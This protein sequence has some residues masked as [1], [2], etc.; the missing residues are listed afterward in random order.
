MVWLSLLDYLRFFL[1]FFDLLDVTQADFIIVDLSWFFIILGV[2]SIVCLLIFTELLFIALLAQ[3]LLFNSLRM[4][5]TLRL[6]FILNVFISSQIDF[7]LTTSQFLILL[8]LSLLTIFLRNDLEL[9]LRQS[10]MAIIMLDFSVNGILLL[11]FL[12]YFSLSF[13]PVA[14]VSV[15][16]Y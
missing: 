16:Q 10:L 13:H 5:F 1:F 7:S 9:F 15:W 4:L 3:S 8:C 12:T 14:L 11:F 2:L 6:N